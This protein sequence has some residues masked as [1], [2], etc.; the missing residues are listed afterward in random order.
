MSQ[1]G[2]T[3]LF[4]NPI[5]GSGTGA[6]LVAHVIALAAGANSVTSSPINLTSATLIV[7]FAGTEA[8]SSSMSDT[9]GNLYTFVRT[10]SISTFDYMS[11]WYKLAPTVSSSMKFTVS[12][13]GGYPG[14]VVMAFSGTFTALDQQSGAGNSGVT[15][16]QPGSVTP[17]INGGLIV[18]GLAMDYYTSTPTPTVTPLT[19]IDY[20]GPSGTSVGVAS[21]WELQS[22][23]AAINPTWAGFVSA[24]KVVTSMLTFK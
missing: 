1:L 12:S 9:L 4:T 24:G 11:C 7:A 21:A 8:S 20:G 3:Q 10:D 16:I 13:T 5:A 18:S 14:L 6:S 15:S 2:Y 23:S 19:L 22:T 17:S